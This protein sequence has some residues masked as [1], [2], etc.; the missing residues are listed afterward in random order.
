MKSPGKNTTE[1]RKNKD[2]PIAQDEMSAETS[3]GQVLDNKP[4]RDNRNLLDEVR[5]LIDEVKQARENRRKARSE[6]R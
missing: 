3:R 5:N 6:N 2:I 4:A 1:E